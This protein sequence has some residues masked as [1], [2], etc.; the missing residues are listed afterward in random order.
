M[1]AD[2]PPASLSGFF[3]HNLLEFVASFHRLIFS[4]VIL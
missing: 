1:V 3:V 2:F 4:M